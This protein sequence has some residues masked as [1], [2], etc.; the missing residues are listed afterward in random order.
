MQRGGL[1]VEG[2]TEAEYRLR[3]CTQIGH[4][5]RACELWNLC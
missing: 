3:D 4:A 5:K 2:D 1:L